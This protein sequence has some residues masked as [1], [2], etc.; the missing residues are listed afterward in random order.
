[1]YTITGIVLDT[2][3]KGTTVYGNPIMEV[4][5]EDTDS[6]EINRFRISDNASLV[7]EVDNH[8][9]RT[10]PHTYVLTRAGRISHRKNQPFVKH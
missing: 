5:L 7:Y 3:T 8:Y 6:G 10:T 9:L 1:M 2:I 4:I